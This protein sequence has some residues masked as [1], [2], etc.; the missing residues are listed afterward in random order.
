V[1]S[2]PSPD[3]R[4][5]SGRCGVVPAALQEGLR[6]R[7]DALHAV[8]RLQAPNRR[9]VGRPPKR[10]QRARGELLRARR[11]ETQE[12]PRTDTQRARYQR[13]AVQATLP[14]RELPQRVYR[15]LDLH[16]YKLLRVELR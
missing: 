13:I 11:I 6:A 10:G 4:M 5:G 9:R 15:L 2:G 1:P 12:G 14:L 16:S 3:R 7:E 8:V